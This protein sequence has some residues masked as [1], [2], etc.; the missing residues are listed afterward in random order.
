MFYAP[1]NK[2]YGLVDKPCYFCGENF[3]LAKHVLEEDEKAQ[4]CSICGK[5]VSSDGW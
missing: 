2:E 3:T 5:G 4:C 1:P